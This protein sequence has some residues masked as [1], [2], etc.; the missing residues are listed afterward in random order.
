MIIR[1]FEPQNLKELE[2]IRSIYPD[3]I[4]AKDIQNYRYSNIQKKL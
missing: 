1:A 4:Q 3:H 2:A